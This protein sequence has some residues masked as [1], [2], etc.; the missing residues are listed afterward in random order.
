M[1]AEGTVTLLIRWGSCVAIDTTMAAMILLIRPS[2]SESQA[3]HRRWSSLILISAIM[4]AICAKV[5][6]AVGLVG[7][8]IAG[9]M[10][11]TKLDFRLEIFNFYLCVKFESVG[12]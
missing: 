12:C 1:S 6:S 2:D 11:R 4:L 7:A 3:T 5:R 10:F 8:F 9:S